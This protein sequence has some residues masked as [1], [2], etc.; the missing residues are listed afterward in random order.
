[1]STNREK[2][3]E[4]K[5]DELFEK[6]IVFFN[7]ASFYEAHEEWE[8]IWLQEESSEKTFYQGLIVLAGGYHHVQKNRMDPAVKA[9]TKALDKLNHPNARSS[10]INVDRL[11]LETKANLQK[12]DLG[13]EV[14][15][16]KII[17]I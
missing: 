6:G 9:L 7:E 13:Q 17:K 3:S 15:F 16:P 5:C 12:I 14:R 2:L 10:Q 8:I 1:M 4:Q 11:I